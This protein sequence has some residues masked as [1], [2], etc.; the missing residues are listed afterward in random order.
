MGISVDWSNLAL[1]GLVGTW[2]LVVGTL[3]L[4]W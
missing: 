4:M 3:I 1:W 2:V